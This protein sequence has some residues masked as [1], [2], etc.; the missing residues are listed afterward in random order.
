MT[1]KFIVI[2]FVGGL[3]PQF[4][5]SFSLSPLSPQNATPRVKRASPLRRYFHILSLPGLRL[6]PSVLPP[7]R[8]PDAVLLSDQY[9]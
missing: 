3:I 9:G 8:A 6:L 7:P 4:E 2:K 1:Y 5:Y